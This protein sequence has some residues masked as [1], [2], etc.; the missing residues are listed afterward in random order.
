MTKTGADSRFEVLKDAFLSDLLKTI[1]QGRLHD[2]VEKYAKRCTF[3]SFEKACHS[4]LDSREGGNFRQKNKHNVKVPTLEWNKYQAFLVAFPELVSKIEETKYCWEQ[5]CD[6]LVHSPETEPLLEDDENNIIIDLN[7]DAL[8]KIL[9]E[10]GECNIDTSEGAEVRHKPIVVD[11]RFIPLDG[12]LEDDV[13]R[14]FVLVETKTKVEQESE[15]IKNALCYLTEDLN[16]ILIAESKK[17][18]PRSYF[19]I[20]DGK[21]R[22]KCEGVAA[23]MMKG[24][25]VFCGVDSNGKRLIFERWYVLFHEDWAKYGYEAEF[26]SRYVCSDDGDPAAPLPEAVYNNFLDKDKRLRVIPYDGS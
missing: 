19:K 6:L 23:L 22:K 13:E 5:L 10:F 24:R 4:T 9:S 2:Q 7:L 8:L 21:E 14:V 18:C 26:K 12:E 15:N 16:Q 25:G 11:V 3:S 20:Y 17:F 1:G